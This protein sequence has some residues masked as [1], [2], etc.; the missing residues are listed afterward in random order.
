MKNYATD[1]IPWPYMA[2]R[3][4]LRQHY[5]TAAAMRLEARA[6]VGR[7]YLASLAPVVQEQ[8]RASAKRLREEAAAW[9]RE[10]QNTGGGKQ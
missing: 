7:W 6:C 8:A 9:D 1:V 5:G 3:E 4:W 10:R 2:T